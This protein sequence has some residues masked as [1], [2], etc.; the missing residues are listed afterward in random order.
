M[1]DTQTPPV[2]KQQYIKTLEDYKSRLSSDPYLRLIDF[3]KEQHTDYRQLIYWMSHHQLSVRRLQAEARI[4]KGAG[5][6]GKVSS[7]IS[8]AQ[9]GELLLE[10]MGRHRGHRILR[11]CRLGQQP[12]RTHEPPCLGINFFDYFSDILGKCAAM[13]NGAPPE[14]Y[15]N[16]LP[17]RWAKE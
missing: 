11:R 9:G 12:H 16:L 3:C 2:A 8:D 7:E 5:R 10:R 1:E 4:D 15:R 14:A 17:D 13:P 6:Y